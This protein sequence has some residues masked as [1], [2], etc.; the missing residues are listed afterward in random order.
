MVDCHRKATQVHLGGLVHSI[1]TPSERRISSQKVSQGRE[2]AFIFGVDEI[3]TKGP[4][5]GI[6]L[7]QNIEV[8]LDAGRLI[9]VPMPEDQKKKKILWKV[10]ARVRQEPYTAAA[11]LVTGHPHDGARACIIPTLLSQ[12]TMGKPQMLEWQARYGS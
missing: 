1:R 11:P 2:V 3:C 5:N 4:R 6:T 12:F 7:H 8:A 10:G 9:I